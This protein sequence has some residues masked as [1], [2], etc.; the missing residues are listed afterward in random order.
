MATP[1]ASRSPKTRVTTCGIVVTDG[2]RILLGHASRSPRWDIP[3][4]VALAGESFAA[5]ALREL[6]EETGLEAPAGSLI[7]L[8]IHRYLPNKDLALFGWC[9]PVMPDPATLSCRSTFETSTGALLPEFDRFGAFPI[10]E[11][12]DRV[13]K[14]LARIL[15]ELVISRRW[16]G[17]PA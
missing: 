15:D 9:P 12:R 3:K 11:A 4:G 17:F 13:G 8:G 2:Q 16:P 7:D 6:A 14:N 1:S 5:A 10:A